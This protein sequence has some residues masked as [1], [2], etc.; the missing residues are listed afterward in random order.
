MVDSG[1]SSN[2]RFK[3][4]SKSIKKG[5][6]LRTALYLRNNCLVE[7]IT[8]TN[9]KHPGLIIIQIRRVGFSR[10]SAVNLHH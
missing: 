8:E 3:T 4:S 5:C 1:T 7:N 2:V 10:V 6:P 9:L